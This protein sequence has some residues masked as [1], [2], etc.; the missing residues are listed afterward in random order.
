MRICIFE[1]RNVRNLEPLALT[2]PA[3]DLRC[4]A[5]TLLQRQ[6]CHFGAGEVGALVRP[7][8]HEYAA[9]LHPE[10]AVNSQPWLKGVQVLVNAR[11]LPNGEPF[12]PVRAAHV[13]VVGDQVAYVAGPPE[14]L[15]ECP[16]AEVADFVEDCTRTLPRRDAGGWMI[17]FPWDLVEHN[18]TALEWDYEQRKGRGTEAHGAYV[19]GP[20]ERLIVEAGARIDPL[21]V[22]DTTKGPVI[23]ERGAVVHSFT[24]LEG[25]CF[26]GAD[27]WLLG[28]KIRG[29]TVGPVCRVGGEVEASILHGYSNKA[30]D[31]FLGH[32]YLGEWVNFGAG[33]QTSDLR[34][35]Y[36]PVSVVLGGH[37]VNSGLT[38]VGSFVGDHT[39]TGLNTLL[40]TGTVVGPFCHLLASSSYVPK[41]VPAFCS[42]WHGQL[43][44]RA[45]FRQL[46]TTAATVMRRRDREWTAS[47]ADFFLALYDTTAAYRRQLLWEGEK[48]R[49]R[50]SV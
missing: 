45:D 23:I 11:W 36:G 15:S 2:R 48:R 32:S 33:T 21:V 10:L 46:F 27:S 22:A 1:D 35:D 31:G 38:K 49:L 19:V 24:T 7:L 47:H 50:R 5:L 20:R 6:R 8:L 17:D 40:N 14:E 29:S 44:D 3:F 37:K 26:I 13:G 12:R 4:G 41:V 30:H 16:P 18:G 39:K 25:P 43:Q 9:A 28:A 42:F 34:N